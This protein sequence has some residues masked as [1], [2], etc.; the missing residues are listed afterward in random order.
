MAEVEQ[1]RQKSSFAF[2]EPVA[3]NAAGALL[4]V[5]PY[6][7]SALGLQGLACLASSSRQLRQ[8]CVDLA[9]QNAH[10]LLLKALPPAKPLETFPALAEA[11]LLLLDG[12]GPPPAADQ[13]LLPVLWLVHVAPSVIDS[14]FT[15]ADVLQRLVHLP[16]VD[17][18]HAQQLV[19]AGV[20]MPYAQLLAAARSM[21]AGVEVWVE[22][23]RQAE[24]ELG[25]ASAVPAAAL[26]ICCGEDLVSMHAYG[27]VGV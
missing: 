14:A 11:A 23:Q 9:T 19:A 20:R 15:A 22:A 6:L 8:S 5:L 25:V 16:N 1:S 18:Q 26:A 21:V 7:G 24:Q 2:V 10:L 13:C 4:D 27:P 17:L 3:S 12:K